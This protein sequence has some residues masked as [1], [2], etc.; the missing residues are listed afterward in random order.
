VLG[1]NSPGALLQPKPST[2]TQPWDP[3]PQPAPGS[4]GFSDA[5]FGED[6]AFSNFT[7]L[8]LNYTSMG[9]ET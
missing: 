9:K 1:G 2:P 8:L 7:W 5:V 3:T 4:P 6:A